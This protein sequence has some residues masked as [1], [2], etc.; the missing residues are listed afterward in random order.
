MELIYLILGAVIL[1][2]ALWLIIYSANLAAM[3]KHVSNCCDEEHCNCGYN[4]PS[5]EERK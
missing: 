2:V 3:N 1:A 5:G 4:P